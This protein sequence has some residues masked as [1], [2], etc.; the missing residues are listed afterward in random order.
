MAVTSHVYPKALTALAAKTINLTS[1]T[2]KAILCTGDASVWGA[3]QEAY[4]FVSTPI[5]AY[6]EVSSG[7]YARVTL[8]TLAVTN[9]GATMKWS[10]DNISWGTSITLSARSMLIIDSSIGA[11]VDAATPVI[12]VVDFGATVSSVSGTFQYNIDGTNGLALWTAS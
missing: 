9:S 5:A 3:T 2:F 1:D 10:C 8:T 11:G 12:A 4:Q 6:T 7:G